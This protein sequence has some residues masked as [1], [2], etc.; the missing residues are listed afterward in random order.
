MELSIFYRNWMFSA[1]H[2]NKYWPKI[3]KLDDAGS[4]RK[5]LKL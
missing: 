1:G 2:K 5:L 3:N 4:D